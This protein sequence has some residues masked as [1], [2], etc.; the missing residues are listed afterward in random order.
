MQSDTSAK[1]EMF[2]FRSKLGY[3]RFSYVSVLLI[4][5]S[6]NLERYSDYLFPLLFC[7]HACERLYGSEPHPAN[8]KH[9][10]V[11]W[12]ERFVKRYN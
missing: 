4:F 7:L 11:V 3:F 2:P 6:S 1:Q 5:L 10:P 12:W 8:Y 9:Q